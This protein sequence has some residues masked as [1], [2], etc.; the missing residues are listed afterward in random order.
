MK[1]ESQISTIIIDDSTKA[2]RLLVLMLQELA[3]NIR[4]LA[5]ASN[6]DEA[7]KLIE[8][9]KP[10]SIFLDIEMPGKSGLE[11]VETLIDK[12]ISCEVIFTTAYNEYAIK[13]FRLSAIDYLLKPIKEHELVQ[14]IEKI[15]IK[16]SLVESEKRLQTLSQNLK[17]DKPNMICIPV[18]NGYEY[19]SLKEIEYIEASGSYADI[20]LVSGK[21]KTISKN[22]KFFEEMLQSFNQFVRVHRSTIVNAELVKRFS[23]SESG[24]IILNSGKLV[25]LARERKNTFFEVMEKYQKAQ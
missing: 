22:L 4:V 7:L 11:L 24:T 13:A 15:Q 10:E 20:T 23:R 18:L 1:S 9:M 21:I 3:P 6:V 2:R 16:R 14:S 5:E 17:S 8:E 25:S 19:I 12:K